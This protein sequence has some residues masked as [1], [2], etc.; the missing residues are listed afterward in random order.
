MRRLHLFE[1]EDQP[2][3]PHSLREIVTQSLQL[4][5]NSFRVY[6]PAVPLI[7]K[8]LSRSRSERVV[9]LCSGSG[10]PWTRLFAPL[11]EEV[12]GVRVTLT[13]RFPQPAA[14]PATRAIDGLSYCEEAVDATDVPASLV[15]LRTLFTGFHHFTPDAATRILRDAVEHRAPIAVFESTQRR[16]LNVALAATLGPLGLLVT[17]PWLRPFRWTHL[18][19]GYVLPVAPLVYAW[20]G[21]VSNVRTY[22]PDELR[23]LAGGADPEGAYEWDIGQLVVPKAPAPITYLV[24][25]PRD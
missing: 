24:G 17:L 25:W 21:A 7:A 2:W 18:L 12:P 3:L 20:D 8:A 11:R 5:V 15:G 23:V 19:W 1:F 9:D 16:A 4:M 10:G 14:L 13:D 6:D 22:G